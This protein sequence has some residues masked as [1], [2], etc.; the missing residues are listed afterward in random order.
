MDDRHPAYDDR[1]PAYDNGVLR[2]TE[3]ASP[4]GLAIT[5]EID[6]GTYPALV[7]SLHDIAERHHEFHLDLSG[8]SYCDLAGLRAIVRLVG[9]GSAGPVRRVQLDHVPH[10]VRMAL[11]VTGWDALPGLAVEPLPSW[12]GP[13]RVSRARPSPPTSGAAGRC[14]RR[15]PAG[16]S[17]GG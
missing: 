3:T 4:A 17:P 12:P 13:W 10:H 16:G 6:E 11:T 9:D 7:T 5:G 1:H 8:V 2:I 14:A 15:R